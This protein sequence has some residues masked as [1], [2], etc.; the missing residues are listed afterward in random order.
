MLCILRKLPTRAAV[1][2]NQCPVFTP[3]QWHCSVFLSVQN[4]LLR[5]SF[6]VEDMTWKGFYLCP[7]QS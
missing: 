5:S 1:F 4:I 2:S 3:V 6:S 7:F